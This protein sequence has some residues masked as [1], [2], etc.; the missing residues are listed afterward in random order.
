MSAPAL[1]ALAHGTR[2]PRSV[3]TTTALGAQVRALRGDL[4]TEIAFL[5]TPSLETPEPRLGAVVDRLVGEGYD[6]VV[7]VPLLL[8]PSPTAVLDVARAVHAATARH[9]GL[10]AT[11]TGA[12]GLEPSFLAVLDE[13][14]RSALRASRVRELDALVLAASGSNDPLALASVARLARRWGARHRLPVSAAYASASAP[15]TGEAVQ[16]LRTE[17]RRHVAVGSLFLSPGLMASR[18][19]ETA[20]DAGAVAVSGPLGAHRE[21]AR[22]VLARYAVGAVDLVP[23]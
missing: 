20:R 5:E 16:A 6:E 10:A 8:T 15:R 7:V 14:L 3:A 2:D 12:L 23:V 11:A 18:A 19:A 9:P 21:V 17:G 13:R 4:R 1:V 22:A